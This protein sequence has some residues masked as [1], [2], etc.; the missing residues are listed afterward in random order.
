MTQII[1]KHEYKPFESFSKIKLFEDDKFIQI[2]GNYY[3]YYLELLIL[4][5]TVKNREEL[6]LKAI[7]K[8]PMEFGPLSIPM[9][10]MIIRNCDVNI[11]KHFI[12]KLP[13]DINNQK[14]LDKILDILIE[15]K[16]YDMILFVLEH[17]SIEFFDENIYTNKR[18]KIFNNVLG[19]KDLNFIKYL[20]EEEGLINYS[21]YHIENIIENF[22]KRNENI[23]LNKFLFDELLK[24]ENFKEYLETSFQYSIYN[25]NI[26]YFNY[27]ISHIKFKELILDDV[28]FE[29]ENIFSMFYKNS[30]CKSIY[31]QNHQSKLIYTLLCKFK[32]LDIL[33]R[34]LPQ[35]FKEIYY[36][37]RSNDDD[38]DFSLLSTMLKLPNIIKSL[39]LFI[40]KID[41]TKLHIY[42]QDNK[43]N[44]TRQSLFKYGYYDT[45]DYIIDN[46][47]NLIFNKKDQ[48]IIYNILSELLCNKNIKYLKKF[49][50]KIKNNEIPYIKKIEK[51][52]RYLYGSLS[53]DFLNIET[54]WNNI[55][56]K[57]NLL[58]KYFDITPVKYEL[59]YNVFNDEKIQKPA[60]LKAFILK[61]Y[62]STYNI[63]DNLFKR[64][65]SHIFVSI[66]N[67]NDI[68]LLGLFLRIIKNKFTKHNYCYWNLVVLGLENYSW[69]SDYINTIL[70]Y[71][72]PLKYTTL[73][74]KE[75]IIITIARTYKKNNI[76][77]GLSDNDDTDEN[78]IKYIELFKM[79]IKNGLDINNIKKYGRGLLDL[80]CISNT[81]FKA[82]IYSGVD[83]KK[84]F[85]IAI[86]S[87]YGISNLS[88]DWIKMYVLVRRLE[89]IRHYRNKKQHNKRY[90]DSII[91]LL[92]RPPSKKKK[93]LEKG[94]IMYYKNI[95]EFNTLQLENGDNVEELEN[96]NLICRY[97]NPTNISREELT[98][99]NYPIYISQK[100]D[101]INVRNIDKDSLYPPLDDSYDNCILDGEYIEELDM[102]LVFSI[103]SNSNMDNSHFDDIF[104][105]IKLHPYTRNLIKLEDMMLGNHLTESK[106]KL[107]FY[108]EITILF[109]FYY[110][111]KDIKHKWFPKIFYK[112]IDP[113]NNLN[114]MSMMEEYQNK[115]F[116]QLLGKRN[117]LTIESKEYIEKQKLKMDGII[118]Y[119]LNDRNKI[120]K[121]KPQNFMTIDTL[122]PNDGQIY[123]SYYNTRIK[124]FEPLEIRT[125]K[126]YPNPDNI[127]VEITNY[128]KN[129][130]TIKDLIKKEKQLPVIQYYQ[131]NIM[132]DKESSEFIMECKY[133]IGSII[134]RRE[135]YYS[136][137]ILDLGCG[138]F[139]NQLWKSDKKIVGVDI[140]KSIH[141]YFKISKD[142]F[143]NKEFKMFDFRKGWMISFADKFDLCYMNMSI[144]YAF[145]NQT[146]IRNFF[147]QLY[148][149]L[150]DNGKVFITFID[151]K[152][153][154]N[155]EQGNIIE[156]S[157]NSYIK[158]IENRIEIYYE[159]RH[160]E[161]IIEPKLDYQL[162]INTFN[163]Y[164][165]ELTKDYSSLF[166][167]EL[168]NNNWSKILKNTKSLFFTKKNI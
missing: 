159:F 141:N 114:I 75:N 94:G 31:Y 136:S 122:N 50:E 43:N 119:D 77:I 42:T 86:K 112:I 6:I 36:Y 23:E 37:S 21:K 62:I 38:Y 51:I 163:H 49:L 134:N 34:I 93:V 118:I 74:I 65:I 128:H 108:S 46:I 100:V 13:V 157:G 15:I 19:D 103:R 142:K 164:G 33:D 131:K 154:F 66:L 3:G 129:P 10:H 116:N 44:I 52:N 107:L 26:K 143:V 47:P 124:Q 139:N 57:I 140:E 55:R 132:K 25:T 1:F 40:P 7:D 48:F 83:F 150:T 61:K 24:L 95:D 111:N 64:Y 127:I 56:K 110:H 120:M 12:T 115:I 106:I 98:N 63:C 125:D 126:K 69:F 76:Y 160:K 60:E 78:Y 91:D 41:K 104:E 145:E 18:Y 138:Y 90:R 144:H 87:R 135:I 102:Y 28:D 4:E 152:E 8:I 58:D 148:K 166:Y 146:T 30:S 161:P 84:Y 67:Q 99:L 105:L 53:F 20:F 167:K 168:E 158:N 92:N 54:D 29:Y 39:E 70:E 81:I 151:S 32:E 149:I 45:I 72:P 88:K 79:F 11:F 59:I 155:N 109:N 16:K 97:N 162:V 14:D 147:K 27:I 89:I 5:P 130:Y 73:E 68:E 113:E 85:S 165:F 35:I 153:L 96:S 82:L 101:G 80:C 137:Y 121:Y 123:R 2:H 117:I 71:C 156:L 9:I 133:A 17:F 22:S